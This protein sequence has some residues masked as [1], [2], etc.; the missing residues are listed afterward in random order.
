MEQPIRDFTRE[1]S[2]DEPK[3]YRPGIVDRLIMSTVGLLLAGLGL[4]LMAM[5][6]RNGQP[7]ALMGLMLALIGL[8]VALYLWRSKII[9]SSERIAMKGLFYNRAMAVK[10]IAGYRTRVVKGST[11]IDLIPLHEGAKRI[12]FPR[13]YTKDEHLTRWLAAL[14]NLDETERREVEAE[15]EQD[16]ALGATPEARKRRV[17][18]SRKIAA[19]LTGASFA[20]AMYAVIYPHPLWLALALLAAGPVLAILLVLVAR[21]DYS[22][23]EMDKKALLKKGG[24]SALFVV[25]AGV[26]LMILTDPLNSLA[27]GVRLGPGSFLTWSLAGALAVT[28]LVAMT[29]EAPARN[30][31]GLLVVFVAMI[32]NTWAALAIANE[33]LDNAQADTYRLQVVDKHK[34]SGKH[35]SY[36]LNVRNV[37]GEPYDGE[38]SVKVGY[39]VYGRLEPGDVV[40]G[41]IHPGAL[42][43]RWESFGEC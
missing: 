33:L 1:Y 17:A 34:N 7:P 8:G 28:L 4:L 31:K 15:I 32:A 21:K 9:L 41:R 30:K 3:V 22:I 42:G 36:W 37:S 29:S 6:G 16:A 11:Y 43:M 26:C 27:P 23:I 40:C 13:N 18:R 35:T 14:P 38:T 25:P 12:T 2:S 24:L 19:G 39:A 10:E 20:G 5:A